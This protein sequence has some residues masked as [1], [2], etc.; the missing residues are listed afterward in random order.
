M[1][2][3]WVSS[4]YNFDFNGMM[5]P[6]MIDNYIHYVFAFAFNHVGFMNNTSNVTH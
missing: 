3:M 4:L 1:Q 5:E 2:Y 6:H